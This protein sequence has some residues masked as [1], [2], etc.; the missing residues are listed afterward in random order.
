VVAGK[1]FQY[2]AFDNGG[3][4]MADEKENV[5][6]RRREHRGGDPTVG[7]II[8]ALIVFFFVNGP[9]S[10]GSDRK[11]TSTDSNFNESAVLGGVDRANNTQNFR[12][13]EASAFMGGINLDLRDAAM[14][15]SEAT[16]H[17]TAVMGGVDIRIPKTWTVVNH[18]TPVMGAVD[19]HT[20]SG[21]GEKKIII[22]GTV[23]MGGLDIKN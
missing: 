23:V 16:I 19:D 7:I 13:G 12:S 5:R 10:H 15:G 8:L 11:G 2:I 1:P 6:P 20:S 14:E 21:D 17:I 9:G 18:V 22:E 4:Q 3:E